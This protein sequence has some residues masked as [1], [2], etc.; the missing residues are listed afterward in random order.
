[1]D[2]WKHTHTTTGYCCH[3]LRERKR[4]MSSRIYIFNGNK[5]IHVN[6]EYEEK[7]FTIWQK[8]VSS[9]QSIMRL[10]HLHGFTQVHIRGQR[11]S[12]FQL[13]DENENFSYSISHME[14]RH[15]FFD[16]WSQTPRRDREKFFFNLSQRDEIEIYYLH[17]QAS[18]RERESLLI[19][20]QFSRREREF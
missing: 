19:W 3:L 12:L 6:S 13:R 14:A 16:T 15:E 20:S 1:M 8:N 4:C 10:C 9:F 5:I 2:C 17:S 7:K 11:E 18:R